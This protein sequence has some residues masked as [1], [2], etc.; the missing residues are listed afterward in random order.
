MWGSGESELA[1]YPNQVIS[2]RIA[3][4]AQ[5]PEGESANEGDTLAT[6]RAVDRLAPF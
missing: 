3:K 1:L 4:A 2:I 5:L 6:V